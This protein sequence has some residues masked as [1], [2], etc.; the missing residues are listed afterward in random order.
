MQ[1]AIGNVEEG[2][3]ISPQIQQGIQFNHDFGFTKTGLGKQRKTKVNGGRIQSINGTIELQSQ[4]IVLIHGSCRL[5]E[6]LGEVG[7]EALISLAV[8]VGQGVSR[9][10]FGNSEVIKF[11]RLGA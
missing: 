9:H 3:I 1:F 7:V 10:P 2:R 8:G 6:S 5:N 11:A 4:S